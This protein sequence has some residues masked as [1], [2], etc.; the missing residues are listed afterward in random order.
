MRYL[1]GSPAITRRAISMKAI[2]I[3]ICNNIILHR[4]SF[5]R[6]R[7]WRF[8]GK[9]QS[10]KLDRV[11]GGESHIDDSDN[12]HDLLSICLKKPHNLLNAID[13]AFQL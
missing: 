10:Y 13:G 3:N 9:M 5:V 2:R 12:S 8:W 4:Y 11:E 1:V 6:N 7:G